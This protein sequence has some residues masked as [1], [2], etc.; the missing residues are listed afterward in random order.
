MSKGRVCWAGAAILAVAA[1][2]ALHG[3]SAAPEDGFA[4]V[5]VGMSES[6]VVAR[7]GRPDALL[8]TPAGRR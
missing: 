4:H 2:L 6:E 1:G 3:L 8:D 7:L 5:E